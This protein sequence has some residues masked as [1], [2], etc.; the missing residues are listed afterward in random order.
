L[1]AAGKTVFVDVTADWCITCQVNKK[2]VLETEEM[3][4]WLARSDVV[5]MR[6]DW[7]SPDPEISDY[8]ASFERYGIPFN[9]VYGPGARGG[10]MLPEIL[11]RDGVRSALRKASNDAARPATRSAAAPG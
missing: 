4:A 6:A 7:T 3:D 8:L 2:L 10:I 9:A 5:A 11:T 1:I